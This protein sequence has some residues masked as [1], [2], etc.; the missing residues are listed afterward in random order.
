MVGGQDFRVCVGSRRSGCRKV[1]GI[2]SGFGCDNYI[3]SVLLTWLLSDF[4]F[5]VAQKVAQLM[6]ITIWEGR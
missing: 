1:L 6:G 4:A 2:A 3:V 5:E